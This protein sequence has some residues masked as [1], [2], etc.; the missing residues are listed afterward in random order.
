MTT[1]H[2]DIVDQFTR[3]ADA[4]ANA[5]PIT[6]ERALDLLVRAAGAT[7]EDTVLDVACGPGLVVC[8]FA[9]DTKHATGIDLTPAMIER[10]RGLQETKGLGNVSWRVGDVLG[11]PFPDG[12]FSIV[13]CR[14]AFHHF[15]EPGLVLAEMV[16]VCRPGGRVAVVDVVASED[17][18]M[19][20]RLNAMDSLRDPSHV[21]FLPES[22]LRTLYVDAGLP[23]PAVEH[24]RLEGDVDS[25]LTR[26]FPN[27][28]DDETI[29]Q[30]FEDSLVDDGMGM[31][32]RR[33]GRLIRYGYPTAILVAS[34]PH[35]R[36]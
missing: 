36:S 18:A 20:A 35:P 29:R 23:D 28:G 9:A 26:S 13:C 8:A 19:A 10:A 11:M 27:A 1:H 32:T 4:F 22:E 25:L 15:P 14:F 33:E 3:Q 16:R 24:Y 21:R 31:G 2:E 17:S 5:P 12:E 34:V 6:D 30:M 7:R